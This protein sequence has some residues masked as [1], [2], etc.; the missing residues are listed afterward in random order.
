[1]VMLSSGSRGRATMRMG[2]TRPA[3]CEPGVTNV[4][5]GW[6]NDCSPATGATST[7]AYTPPCTYKSAWHV[8]D[9]RSDRSCKK[10]FHPAQRVRV[11]ACMNIYIA[12]LARARGRARAEGAQK[13]RQMHARIGP[14]GT[15]A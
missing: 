2:L 3:A 1:M 12:G 15:R 13:I 10:W 8:A 14:W 11:R 7:S 9:K 6:T 5:E 4:S